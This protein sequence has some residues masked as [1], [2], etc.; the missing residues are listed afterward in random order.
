MPVA[1]ETSDKNF[2]TF[3]SYRRLNLVGIDLNKK[4]EHQNMEDLTSLVIGENNITDYSFISGYPALRSLR[5]EADENFD[6]NTLS[7]ES[8]NSMSLSRGFGHRKTTNLE[9]LDFLDNLPNLARLYVHSFSAYNIDA[10]YRIANPDFISLPD[11]IASKVDQSKFKTPPTKIE[12]RHKRT[13][14]HFRDRNI[15]ITER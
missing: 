6:F 9:S 3:V 15:K 8:V 10:L 12:T 1:A 13:I 5:I 11:E 14:Y 4:T 2:R 7:S